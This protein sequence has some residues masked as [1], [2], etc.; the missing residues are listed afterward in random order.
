[1][2][3]YN[4]LLHPLD[5]NFENSLLLKI[6]HQQ[7]YSIK[8][9]QSAYFKFI[10]DEAQNFQVSIDT[11]AGSVRGYLNTKET[12]QNAFAKLDGTNTLKIETNNPNFQT[13]IVYYLIVESVGESKF[14][15]V[16]N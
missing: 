2:T 10:I 13:G 11:T 1:M 7:S 4:I 5:A 15:V 12:T 14:T 16:I 9:K 8:D 3:T 6:G